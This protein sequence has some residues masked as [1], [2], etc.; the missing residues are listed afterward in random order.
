M[1]ALT[2]QLSGVDWAALRRRARHLQAAVA[3]GLKNAVMTAVENDTRAATADSPSPPSAKLLARLAAETANPAHYPLVMA[4]VWGRLASPH[5]RCVEKALDLLAYLLRHGDERVVSELH[6]A[7]PQLESFRAY[8]HP[9]KPGGDPADDAAA[10]G[11]GADAGTRVRAAAAE[12]TRLLGDRRAL[13]EER[14]AIVAAGG[15]VASSPSSADGGGG[16]AGAAAAAAAAP[17]TSAPA[18]PSV[19]PPPTGGGG[20]GGSPLPLSPGVAPASTTGGVGGGGG[21]VWDSF[22]S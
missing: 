20:V 12:V 6:A 13:R 14:A 7:L 11:T 10:L 8:P 21:G 19:L 18:S 1:D 9:K 5:P 17:T 3:S 4:I 15:A 16:A 2:R 22:W